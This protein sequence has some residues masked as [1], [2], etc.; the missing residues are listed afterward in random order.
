MPIS[1]G[2]GT[3]V[4]TATAS[5]GLD[6]VSPPGT[7]GP[8]TIDSVSPTVNLEELATYQDQIT[9]TLRWEGSDTGS[10]VVDYDVGHQYG[11]GGDWQ[12][13][14]YNTVLTEWVY[15]AAGQEGRHNFR[16][17]AYDGAHNV[18][19]WAETGTVVDVTRPKLSL[20]L[21]G[22]PPL[23][24]AVTDTLYYGVGNG[25]MTATAL[26]TDATSGLAQV[27]FPDTTATGTRSH[28]YEFDDSDSFSGTVSITASDR[29]TNI[30]TQPVAVIRDT[31]PPT[32]TV[33]TPEV[34]PLHFQVTWSGEDSESGLRD[35][36]VA[37]KVG[38][39]NWVGWYT[40]TT[41]TQASFIGE[42]DQTYYF[43]IQA[44]DNVSNTSAWV[45][46]DPVTIQAVRKNYH[47]G[48]QLAACP[49]QGVRPAS[50]ARRDCPPPRR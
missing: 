19:P 50:A 10:G 27:V 44:T 32:L 45:E 16:V 17:H 20:G 5:D 12:T 8:V 11:V 15:V 24:H 40:D 3:H 6:Q 13:L 46:S 2:D 21:A 39:G 7:A 43:R 48:G 14:G 22:A 26:L 4:I 42:K 41:R 29:A 30:I 47:F 35:Y 18:S 1:L 23:A 25:V 36:D 37:Y 28:S 49:R 38:S 33:Q 9:V 31:T 34:A